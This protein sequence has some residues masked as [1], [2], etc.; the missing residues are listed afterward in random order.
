MLQLQSSEYADA[1]RGVNLG[2]R[3]LEELDETGKDPQMVANLMLH[4][5]GNFKQSLG[6]IV[7]SPPVYAMLERLRYRLEFDDL[8][9]VGVRK[10][11]LQS[12][13]EFQTSVT[14]EL[15]S[16]LYFALPAADRSL[17]EQPES[18]FGVA[19]ATSFPNASRDMRDCGRCI[20]L[21]LWTASVFHAMRVAEHGI[22]RLSDRLDVKFGKDF[23][24]LTWNEAIVKIDAKIRAL[25]DKHHLTPGRDA[26]VHFGASASAHFFAIKEAWRNYVMHGRSSYDEREARS[27]AEAV[28]AIMIALA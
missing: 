24:L 9:D 7:L 15:R 16:Y 28:R 23:E 8:A 25:K 18:W 3:N 13:D 17:F 11:I 14:I 1:V 22:R 5:L 4:F 10:S 12:L 21:G 19:V 6:Q 26:D 27:I 20:A 2:A